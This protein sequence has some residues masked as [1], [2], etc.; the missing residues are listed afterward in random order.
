MLTEVDRCSI[1]KERF[2]EYE[3]RLAY[4]KALKNAPR[5]RR[6]GTKAQAIID[7]TARA[8]GDENPPKLRTVQ[9]YVRVL[10]AS[11]GDAK[12]LISLHTVSRRRALRT[13]QPI[14]RIMVECPRQA[15]LIERKRGVEGKS[16]TGR[17]ELGG[18]RED[19]KKKREE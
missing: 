16:G 7:D 2:P 1:P 14:V 12:F 18:G 19:K 13:A 10:R 4:A 8:L 6:S 9:G 17:V 15:Y 3:T 11:G 5:G